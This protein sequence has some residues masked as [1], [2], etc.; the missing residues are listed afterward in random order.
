MPYLEFHQACFSYSSTPN[1]LINHLTCTLSNGWTGVVGA[2]GAGKSTLLQL[3]IGNLKAD[4][5][6]ISGP[7]DVLYCPQRTD[8]I[9]AEVTQLIKAND[10]SAYKLRG[11]L[12][13]TD[14][15]LIRWPTLSHGERKRAQIAAA[16][17][18]Q[19]TLLAI[20]EP[21][22]HLD[23][24]AKKLLCEALKAYSGI[25]LLVS[26]D[27]ELLD[28]LCQQCLFMQPPEVIL[29]PGGYSTGSQLRRQQQN[30]QQYCKD[31]AKH[32]LNKL[33]QV[34]NKRRDLAARSHQLRSKKGIDKKDR[35]A[36]SK[37]NLARVSGKDG[38]AG[39]LLNQM[40]GRIQRASEDLSS[41]KIDKQY[42]TGIWLS[43]EKS[44]RQTLLRL[45]E[46]CLSIG[47]R[48]LAT[49]KLTLHRGD[50]IALTG[51]NGSGKSSLVKHLI[52]QLELPDDKLIYLPQELDLNQTDAITQT[53]HS[54]NDKELGRLMTIISRL[55]SRPNRLLHS[56]RASPGEI[57]KLMLAMGIVKQPHLIIM[58]EPT[59]HLD[60]PSIE[61]LQAALKDCPC[62]LLLIS[63]DQVFLDA[64][65][66]INW[67][68]NDT[69]NG[70]NFQLE[71]KH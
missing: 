19:P 37:I 27:R 48:Q 42:Q 5:G 71:I 18:R 12:G 23:R 36:K 57:R 55:G 61:S 4:S 24:Q 40:Q 33:T 10:G 47:R 65:T 7:E 54:L 3:A 56:Q 51:I 28:D 20:D 8:V 29:R 49:P 38:Q 21:T 16:L 58:D 64:L 17:W 39:R 50:R 30:Q 53:L 68:I 63:H 43:V 60:L 41:I 70:T 1:K 44:P 22:N 59:N 9:S 6:H 26:H 52:K 45:P 25:G 34:A 13:V 46:N 67:H 31:Q 14:D 35:D 2:N 66:E 11:Q 32:Q 15:Y 69:K 62:G